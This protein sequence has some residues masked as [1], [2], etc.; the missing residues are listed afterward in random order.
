MRTARRV[1]VAALLAIALVGIASACAQNQDDDVAAPSPAVPVASTEPAAAQAP[2]SPTAEPSLS[3]TVDPSSEERTDSREP[4]MPAAQ[5]QAAASGSQTDQDI[6]AAEGS[7]VSGS[8]ASPATDDV[9]EGEGAA[10]L[11]DD[12]SGEPAYLFGEAQAGQEFGGY[13]IIDILPRDAIAEIFEPEFVSAS[14]A[15]E[16][17]QT[18]ELVLGLTI[19]GDSRAYSLPYLNS[20]EIVNDEVGGKPVAVTW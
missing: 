18:F 7:D 6:V 12:E 14:E 1:R 15:D 13:E 19:D 10:E 2:A 8:E 17:M 16:F 4:P 9:S 5:E 11:T 20:H 3:A